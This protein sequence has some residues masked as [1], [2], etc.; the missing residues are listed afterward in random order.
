MNSYEND[1]QTTSKKILHILRN[2]SS[3]EDFVLN[4][5]ANEFDLEFQGNHLLFIDI[6]SGRKYDLQNLSLRTAFKSF[7]RR[8]ERA[9][10]ITELKHFM[11]NFFSLDKEK[12]R[13]SIDD[14]FSKT[15]NQKSSLQSIIAKVKK[16]TEKTLL[17]TDDI[18]KLQ[19]QIKFKTK[20]ELLKNRKK[21]KVFEK[22][23]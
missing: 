13:K 8:I 19:R 14:F 16:D 1:L 4:V 3:Y 15:D 9:E 20:M 7:T 5:Y 22:A 18:E 17:K 2:S 11:K 10:K 6:N 23:R 12:R 21:R